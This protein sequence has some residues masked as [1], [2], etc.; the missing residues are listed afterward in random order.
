MPLSKI[1]WRFKLKIEETI[2]IE[3]LRIQMKGFIKLCMYMGILC[4]CL[5]YIILDKLQN[6]K[7]QILFFLNN[8][9]PSI[10]EQTLKTSNKMSPNILIF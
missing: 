7:L 9:L 6:F 2:G 3:Q 5:F 8:H 1:T 4:M 10:D